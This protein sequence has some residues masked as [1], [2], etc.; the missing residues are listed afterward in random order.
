MTLK[1]LG[2]L[3]SL[4]DCVGC[5]RPLR[6]RKNRIAFGLVAGGVLCPLCRTGQRHVVGLS[7]AA[8][9]G[10]QAIS[11][12]PEGHR[13]VEIERSI[14]GELRG[15]LGNYISHLLGHRPQMHKFLTT[16]R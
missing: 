6:D 10:L 13:M 14:R 4:V 9:Q 12:D 15:L 8:L 1:D 2:H 16:L 11:A 3:P 7:Q 5:G